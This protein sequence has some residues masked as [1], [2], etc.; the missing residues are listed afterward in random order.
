[1][2]RLPKS[3]KI[4]GHTWRILQ[5][6][7][8]SAK[9]KS[10]YKKTKCKNKGSTEIFMFGLSTWG[11]TTIRIN[12]ALPYQAKVETLIHEIMHI[13]LEELGNPGKLSKTDEEKVVQGTSFMLY[14]LFVDNPA[15]L[16]YIS[17]GTNSR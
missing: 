10:Q 3:V 11:D 14:T 16:R 13:I 9:Y 1:M 2:K 8:T 6:P 17:A 15:I 7:F 4:G 5:A 12:K